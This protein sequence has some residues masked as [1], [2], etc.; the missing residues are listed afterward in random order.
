MPSH[1][2]KWLW[3]TVIESCFVKL[4]EEYHL[5]I[6]GDFGH[7]VIKAGQTKSTKYWAWAEGAEKNNCFINIINRLC[8]QLL[9]IV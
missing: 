2:T 6:D 7:P 9:I 3:N 1:G 4:L 8:V 5:V